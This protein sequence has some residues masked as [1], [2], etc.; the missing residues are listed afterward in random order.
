MNL[1]KMLGKIDM[2]NLKCDSLLFNNIC[3]KIAI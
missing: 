1:R 3:D 2:Y